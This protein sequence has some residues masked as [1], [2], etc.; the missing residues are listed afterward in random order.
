[1]DWM[2]R[3][4]EIPAIWK[5]YRLVI[6]A[7]LVG[8]MLMV[9][10]QKNREPA[11]IPAE[12]H[13]VEEELQKSLS[14]ML[15]KMEGAGRVEVLLTQKEGERT[16][17]QTDENRRGT[18][19]QSDTVLITDTDRSQQGLIRQ[20]DPPVYLG[21]VVLC[22]GADQASVRLHLVEAVKS[23]TGLSSDKITVLKMK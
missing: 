7:T 19:L 12:H 22:Q 21:A 23:V 6:L 20:V 10:P 11:L 3:K 18:D 17:Y 1:M 4:E 13:Q 14:A 5:R 16:I 15:S 9:L 8:I 2:K